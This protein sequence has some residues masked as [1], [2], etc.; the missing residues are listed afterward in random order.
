M[1]ATLRAGLSALLI[2]AVLWPLTRS[3]LRDGFP[4]STYP[5]FIQDRSTAKLYRAVGLDRDGSERRLPPRLVVGDDQEP[6]LSA[7][8]LERAIRKSKARRA[9]LCAE[10]AAA[11]AVDPEFGSLWAVELR[12]ETHDPVA[13]FVDPKAGEAFEPITKTHCKV[14]RGGAGG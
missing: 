7:L 14:K 1:K 8:T 4:F 13:Y 5:M 10:I 11:A 3:V 9:E 2:G 6:M 12:I